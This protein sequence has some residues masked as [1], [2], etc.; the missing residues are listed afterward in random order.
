[1]FLLDTDIISHLIK[2][3]PSPRLIRRL[4]MVS[5]EQHYVSA[6][7]VGELVYGAYLSDR[8]EHFLRQLETR[9]WPGVTVLPFDKAAAQVYG[10][11]RARLE[12][13]GRPRREPDL[14]IAAS[15]LAHDLTL[16]TASVRHFQDI[17]GLRVENWL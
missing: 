2:R 14:Q 13:S 6:I 9:V 12:R 15:A 11:V 4:A 10:R 16:I 17:P 7:T 5:P 3:E 1:V 8:P